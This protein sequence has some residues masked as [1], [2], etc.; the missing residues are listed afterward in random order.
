MPRPLLDDHSQP[1]AP[2]NSRRLSD[3]VQAELIGLMRGLLADGK[4]TDEE[5]L[6]FRD[7]LRATPAAAS[8]WPGKQLVERLLRILDD[9]VI[10][11][12]ERND[13]VALMRDITGDV[14]EVFGAGPS[15]PVYTPT[16]IAFDAPAPTVLVPG[17][18]FVLTGQF[19]TGTRR[20][21]E[22]LIVAAGGECQS[23]PSLQTDYLI[24]GSIG[25]DQWAQSP[26]G[27]KIDKAVSLREKAG[28]IAIVS[29]EDWI[30][31]LG[32]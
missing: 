5:V 9:L 13:L 2:Y 1:L 22:S 15:A 17:R 25:S 4:L 31:A 27:R 6:V 21:C 26:F 24:V 29:E 18:R 8:A 30:I 20:H 14:L 10:T 3:R 19:I 16:R 12:D 23:S 28:R 7:W 11:E 32:L